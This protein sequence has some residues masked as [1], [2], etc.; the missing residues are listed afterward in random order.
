MNNITRTAMITICGRPNVGRANALERF[1][2]C[3]NVLFTLNFEF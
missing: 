1:Y 3:H 2:Y